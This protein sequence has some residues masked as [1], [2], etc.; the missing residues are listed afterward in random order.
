MPYRAVLAFP[1]AATLALA[2]CVFLIPDTEFD[3]AN[4]LDHD[5]GRILDTDR[6]V[7]TARSR[8]DEA[9]RNEKGAAAVMARLTPLDYRCIPEHSGLVRCRY[10]NHLKWGVYFSAQRHRFDYEAE[11]DPEKGPGKVRRLCVTITLRESTSAQPPQAPTTRC[12]PQ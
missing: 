8:L 5:R 11:I 3:P 7:A 9:L 12:D 1:L 2:G 4:P 6:G 10:A